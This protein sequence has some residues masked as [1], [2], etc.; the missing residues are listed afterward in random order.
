MNTAAL[1]ARYVL[2]AESY[3]QAEDVETANV[4]ADR[5]AMIYRGI[6]EA[7]TAPL[8]MLLPL[9]EHRNPSVKLWAASHLL[10][11]YPGAASLTL[12][13]L[14]AGPKGAIRASARA[15]LDCWLNASVRFP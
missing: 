2:D 13:Q 6:R 14:A 8:Q 3:G 12:E 5:L 11:A 4:A 15:T 1:I 10:E 9:L 7:G